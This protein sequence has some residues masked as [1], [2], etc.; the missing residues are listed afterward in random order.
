[1]NLIESDIVQAIKIRTI[2]HDPEE[3]KALAAIGAAINAETQEIAASEQVDADTTKIEEVQAAPPT[4]P[5]VE[6]NEEE[7]K[8]P[9]S[10][11][12]NLMAKYDNEEKHAAYMKS[13]A[14]KKSIKSKQ[15]K[16]IQKQEAEV[17]ELEA[18]LGQVEASK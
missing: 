12:D 18:T 3:D 4:T 7:N 2:A 1:M 5:V 17:Q 8:S 16:E 14:Y 11:V 15:D 10:E 9:T 13:D 6:N